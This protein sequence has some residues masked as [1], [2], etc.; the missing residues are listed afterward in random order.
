MALWDGSP[1]NS[2][3]KCAT[4]GL[5][6]TVRPD[7]RS[8]TFDLSYEDSIIQDKKY[9]KSSLKL[10]W[11]KAIHDEAYYLW[12]AQEGQLVL[13][14]NETIAW[15]QN[16]MHEPHKGLILETEAT[17]FPESE[18]VSIS[19]LRLTGEPILHTL[20]RPTERVKESTTL[21]HGIRQRDVDDAPSF[22]DLHPTLKNLLEGE[23][24][25]CHNLEFCRWTLDYSAQLAGLSPISLTEQSHCLML[26]YAG[27]LGE[28]SSYDRYLWERLEG[29]SKHRGENSY[30]L[31][32][33]LEMAQASLLVPEEAFEIYLS[34]RTQ[35]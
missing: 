22:A 2:F 24:V 8:H 35:Q 10:L 11:N 6:P 15:A 27:F 4:M 20:V 18:L 29:A 31:D 21:V 14:R 26:A 17:S 5:L 32:I 1:H 33:L 25:Y 7:L 19:I 34:H 28:E 9:L 23:I 16:V 30:G 3:I 13:E 12:L